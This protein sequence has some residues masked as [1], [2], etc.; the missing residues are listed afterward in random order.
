MESR[1]ITYSRFVYTL[2]IVLPL[3]AIGLLSTVFLFTKDR[4]LEGGLRFSK[5]DF[6][7]LESGMQVSKPRFSG[8][9][10]QG[11]TYN[12]T[13]DVL[14]PDAPKPTRLAATGLSG[15]M[16][17]LDGLAIQLSAKQADINLND[18]TVR[19]FNG[20]DV[21]FS[22]GFRAKT[23]S[24][25]ANLEAGTLN[26]AGTVRATSPMG[27][28]AAGNLRVETLRI[29]ERENRMIWFENGV[30]LTFK[31]GNPPDT[32]QTPNE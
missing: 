14:Y 5:A 4:T 3:I 7:T 11:D 6:A 23:G 10:A 17:M 15:E 1:A 25:F 13:A 20:T 31:T 24:I 19:L 2:K 16:Q 27:K 30:K 29:N 22:D 32:G 9:N 18:R 21:V 8:S 28:I 26:T 12:F